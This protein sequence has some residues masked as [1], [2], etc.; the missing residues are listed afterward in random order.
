M[1]VVFSLIVMIILFYQS[2]ESLNQV[3]DG[4]P[5]CKD[6]IYL[7]K[8]HSFF[9]FRAVDEKKELNNTKYFIADRIDCKGNLKIKEYLVKNDHLVFEGSYEYRKDT[10][11]I[12]EKVID[13]FDIIIV[14]DTVMCHLTNR[15]GVWKYYSELDN[16]LIK[17][18]KYFNGTLIKK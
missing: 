5:S 14:K 17:E 9:R 18:E 12:I 16:K 2:L 10:I 1:K 7:D 3:N 11:I 8:Y 15:T 13:P 6:P 4:V